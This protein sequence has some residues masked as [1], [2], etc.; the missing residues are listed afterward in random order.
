RRIPSSS[1]VGGPHRMRHT[2]RPASSLRPRAARV[3]ARSHRRA[4]PGSFD[5]RGPMRA[6][7]RSPSPRSVVHRRGTAERVVRNTLLKGAVQATRLLSLIFVILAAR[8][9][10]SFIELAAAVFTGFERIEFELGLRLVEKLVLIGIGVTGL[11]LGG[12]LLLVAGAFAIAA[13]VSLALGVTLANRTFARLR[14]RM[15][16]REAWVLARTLGPVAIAFLLSF[17]TT[18][19]VPLVVALVG[20]DVAAGHF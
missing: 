7:G 5:E 15:A 20:G 17:A 8:A 11:L 1:V 4:S 16:P 12:G 9:L 18:R 14:W 19:L 6:P 2:P 3:S 13:A 10:Q